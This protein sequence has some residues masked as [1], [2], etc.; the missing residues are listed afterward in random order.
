MKTLTLI[1]LSASLVGWL[2]TASSA[3][4]EDE[5]ELN[6]GRVIAVQDRP[7]RMAHEFTVSAG[8]LPMDAFYT[9]LSLGGS[10]TLHLTE[11]FAWEAVSF[12]YSG[13]VDK[14]LDS[15]LVERWSAQAEGEP[16]IQYLVGS[17]VVFTPLFGKLSVFNDDIVFASTYLALGGGLAKYTDGFRPQVSVGPGIRL[18][19]NQVVSTRLDLRNIIA[20]DIPEGLEYIL[21]VSLSVSF[22]F[23]TRATE[24]GKEE[25]VTDFTDPFAELDELYPLSNPKRD[26][27]EERPEGQEDDDR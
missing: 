22:N 25:E 26:L 14:G 4:A 19:W 20:P 7:F 5:D 18:F 2:A 1:T 11:L 27:G 16:E 23:G 15:T 24:I 6:S 17:N 13:N 21:H 10:Y 9:G 12:H 3:R 8:V